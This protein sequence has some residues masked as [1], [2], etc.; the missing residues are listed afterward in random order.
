MSEHE[1]VAPSAT[2]RRP[3]ADTAL[4]VALLRDPGDRFGAT[5]DLFRS[6]A[7]FRLHEPAFSRAW[8][9]AAL[10]ASTG[11]PIASAWFAETA[12]GEARSGARGP[13]GAFHTPFAPLPI[14]VASRLI[15]ATEEE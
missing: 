10:D 2:A 4:D 5:A 14:G 3:T 8:Y 11:D 13:Y 7:F 9:V 15:A 6:P 12:P 1:T